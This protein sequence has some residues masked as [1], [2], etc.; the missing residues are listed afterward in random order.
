MKKIAIVAAKRSP[1]GRI[2]GEL[3]HVNETELLAIIMENT[4]K[5][6][7]SYIDEAILGSSFPIEKD[8]LCRKALLK[9]GLSPKIPAFTVSKTCASSDEALSIAC[10]KIACQQA[11]AVLVCGSEKI[12]NSSYALHFLK[13]DVKRAMKN[14][15][16]N[17]S[18]I[19]DQ[20]LENDMVYI[21]E[22]LARKYAISRMESDD[23]TILNIGRANRA[24][25]NGNFAEEIVPISNNIGNCLFIDEWLSNI[26]QETDIN[27]APPM[28]ILDGCITK[29]NAAP[30]CDNAAAMILMDYEYAHE[31]G[32]KPYGLIHATVSTG[33]E[34]DKTG[35]AMAK[36]VEKILDDTGLPLAAIDLFEINDSF[37][38]QALCTMKIAGLSCDKVNVNGGNLALGYPIGATGLRMKISLLYEMKRRNV[39]YGLSVMCA[40]GN[41][42]N[43]II[44]KGIP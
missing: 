41:M 15:L 25:L 3:S 19:S 8:N 11:K 16:K 40:G 10:N 30:V 12:N 21:N 39:E 26:R 28:F 13:Q 6:F 4:A 32:L 18:E 14:E 1:I 22:M 7:E 9:A 42:A 2:P 38:V 44:I 27:A 31:L 17:F 35:T 20:I 37:A 29:Y 5:G 43:G 23:F 36:C 33:V 24:Y 34:N